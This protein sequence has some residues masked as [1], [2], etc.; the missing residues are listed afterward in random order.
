MNIEDSDNFLIDLL[1]VCEKNDRKEIA[2]NIIEE[3]DNVSFTDISIPTYLFMKRGLDMIYLGGNLYMFI[4]KLFNEAKFVDYMS[5]IVE[6]DSVQDCI[7]ATMNL[8]KVFGEPDLNTTASLI[9]RILEK[10]TYDDNYNAELLNFLW[11]RFERSAPYKDKPSWII[12]VEYKQSELYENSMISINM[13]IELFNEELSEDLKRSEEY[14]MD[15]YIDIILFFQVDAIP[16]IN[17]ILEDKEIYVR[18]L[19]KS[20]E[21]VDIFMKPYINTLALSTLQDDSYLYKVFGP[22]HPRDNRKLE[23]NSTDICEMFGGDRM[24][25]C[26]DNEFYTELEVP[27]QTERDRNSEDWFTGFCM[28]CHWKIREKHYALR[29]PLIQGGWYG[30]YCSFDCIRDDGLTIHETG[31]IVFD[32]IDHLEEL[33]VKHGIFDRV[34]DD[35]YINMKE[36]I[37]YKPI[38]EDIKKDHIDPLDTLVGYNKISDYRKKGVEV[39]FEGIMSGL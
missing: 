22:C 3:W 5:E 19:L 17:K 32:L 30:C 24:F 34:W 23:I 21:N 7:V 38:D 18:N 6:Y 36:P 8:I 25:L 16:G 33:M 10:K 31:T 12:D 15:K 1:I 4:A 27:E 39:E 11:E 37:Y 9:T 35:N 14:K 2:K 13:F 26:K 29:I 20:K 28:Y